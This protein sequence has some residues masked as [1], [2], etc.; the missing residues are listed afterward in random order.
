MAYINLQPKPE[1]IGP[2]LRIPN[3]SGV[4]SVIFTAEPTHTD[5]TLYR[6]I[7]AAGG[8][9]YFVN[10]KD[11]VAQVPKV[12]VYRADLPSKDASTAN[13]PQL[14]D[15][16]RKQFDAEFLARFAKINRNDFGLTA[17]VSLKDLNRVA[18]LLGIPSEKDRSNIWDALQL[19]SKK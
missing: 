17:T 9:G 13:K 16:E 10:G 15:A 11:F 2:P 18:L 8:Q 4:I 14:T 19:H 12:A 6:K 5:Q 7:A 1:F 3:G